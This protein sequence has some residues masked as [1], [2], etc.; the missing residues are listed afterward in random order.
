[1]ALKNVAKMLSWRFSSGTT[2]IVTKN[3]GIETKDVTISLRL[4]LSLFETLLVWLEHTKVE[5]EQLMDEC[6]AIFTLKRAFHIDRLIWFGIIITLGVKIGE[7]IVTIQEVKDKI[8]AIVSSS[9]QK[10]RIINAS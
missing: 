6:N 10:E 8:F 7:Q 3:G 5:A 4:M 9:Y 1:M 2:S